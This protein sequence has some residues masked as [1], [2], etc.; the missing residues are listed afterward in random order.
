MKFIKF[1]LCF[2]IITSLFSLTVFGENKFDDDKWIEK[3]LPLSISEENDEVYILTNKVTG[4]EIT[5]VYETV[6]GITRKL[7]VEEALEK[8]NSIPV[9]EL[10]K[11]YENSNS[12][13]D[14]E[15]DE[16]GYVKNYFELTSGPNKVIGNPRKISQDVKGPA[17]IEV[18][19]G[20]E[21]TFSES[22]S[23]N[24]TYAMKAEIALSAGIEWSKSA[25][26]S[27][28]VTHQVPSGKMG[29]VA[30]KPYYYEIKG[31]YITEIPGVTVSSKKI[32]ARTPITLYNGL[33]DG[34]EYV[35]LN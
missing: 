10:D 13:Y 11:E 20:Q 1:L 28:S 35:V 30:F 31:N 33:C 8:L 24:V 34:L 6:N 4:E 26:R 5:D 19:Q 21:F 17:I 25:T 15:T 29:H 32:S 22:F 27:I 9:S 3:S 18:S 16:V 12:N 2:F 23:S 14:I 7:S